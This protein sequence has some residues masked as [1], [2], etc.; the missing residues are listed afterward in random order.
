VLIGIVFAVAVGVGGGYFLRNSEVSVLD[1]QVDSWT[2]AATR[3]ATELE[4]TNLSLTEVS[5][6]VTDL[7]LDV[8]QRDQRIVELEAT[9]EEFVQ[10]QG[11]YTALQNAVGAVQATKGELEQAFVD[12]T[13]AHDA[14]SAQW[15]NLKPIFS[16]DAQG[17]PIR[18]DVSSGAFARE[19]VCTGS[20]EPSIGCDDVVVH[21]EVDPADLDVGDVIRF[22]QLSSDCRTP[23]PGWF[24]VHRIT[25]TFLRDGELQFNTKGDANPLPDPCA[26]PAR[27]VVSKVIGVLYN[28]EIANGN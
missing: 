24:F 8:Q 3:S 16:A 12:L 26:V 19:L 18:V 27:H 28:S 6:Q 13:L 14:L 7:R 10:L 2:A 9:A 22:R 15:A 25:N 5:G 23:V 21:L 20:M 1:E 11:S 4:Q 17:E